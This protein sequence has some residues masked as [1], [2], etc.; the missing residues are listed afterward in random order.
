[1]TIILDTTPP[2]FGPAG[3]ALRLAAHL[4]TTMLWRYGQYPALVTL[5]DPAIS[6]E[7]RA[8]ADL[9]RLWSPATLDDPGACLAMARRTATG[10]G[11]PAVCCIHFQTARDEGYFPRLDSRLLTSH[12][13]PE[14]PPAA[15][16]S[17][18]HVHLPPNPTQAQLI[19]V[20]GR[21]LTA[22]SGFDGESPG[23][24]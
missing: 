19:T 18:W 9:V 10:L 14:R 21:M 5:T 17:P 23:T 8:P 12:Q 6:V 15:P 1:M 4:M 16:T 3:N 13:P 7:L 11:Q 20:V 22:S 2:T 24:T